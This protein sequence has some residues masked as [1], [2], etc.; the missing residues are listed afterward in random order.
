ME[1]T[2][3]PTRITGMEPS[4]F[5]C[6]TYKQTTLQQFHVASEL[7][8]TVSFGETRTNGAYGPLYTSF[9]RSE[10]SW[11]MILHCKRQ[12]QFEN[13][14]GMTSYASCCRVL[15]DPLPLVIGDSVDSVDAAI[16]FVDL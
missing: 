14:V 12:E 5:P 13:E 16:T 8:F 15:G 4:D 9:K 2:A 11:A 7:S 10:L 1:P 6:G 3:S